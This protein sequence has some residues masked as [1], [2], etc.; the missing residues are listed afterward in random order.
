[1]AFT[2]LFS[3]PV[4]LLLLPLTCNAYLNIAHMVNTP[5]TLNWA[6][7]HNGELAMHAFP[8]RDRYQES[9]IDAQP[10]RR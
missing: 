5:E 1:M 10:M 2:F 7:D 3:S 9:K 8:E 6:V 4:L